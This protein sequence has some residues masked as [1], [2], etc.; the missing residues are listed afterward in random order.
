MSMPRAEGPRRGKHLSSGNKTLVLFDHTCWSLGILMM[1]EYTVD[2]RITV[3][4]KLI[5]NEKTTDPGP[6]IT[7]GSLEVRLLVEEERL[8]GFFL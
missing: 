2:P 3:Y 1:A 6:L 7:E 8:R 5:P 4:S